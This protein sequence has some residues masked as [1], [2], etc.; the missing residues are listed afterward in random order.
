MSLD[1]EAAWKSYTHSCECGDSFD[2]TNCAH[3][4]SNALIKG[5]FTEIDGQKGAKFRIVNGFCVCTHGR[6]VRAKEMRAW[7]AR[8]WKRQQKPQEGYNA[9]Y[10]QRAD[11]Q[12]HV[13]LLKG[14]D[15]KSTDF[16]GTGNYHSWSIQEYYY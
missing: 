12:G 4:L 14:A 6:P 8:K 5:G 1:I 11:G 3:F 7:F 10:Q 16:K 9:V 13:L 2:G 15:P